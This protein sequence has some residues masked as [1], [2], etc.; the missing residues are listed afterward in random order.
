MS[1]VKIPTVGRLVH[2]FPNGGDAHCEKNNAKVLPATVV[3]A[4]G[5][6]INLAVTC[7]NPDGPVV[8][9]CSV[10]HLSSL[11]KKLGTDALVNRPYWDWP[12]IQ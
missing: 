6:A 1:D 2:Y 11:D 7:M 8:L 10:A 12:E 9:R 3:Q 4:F 5:T